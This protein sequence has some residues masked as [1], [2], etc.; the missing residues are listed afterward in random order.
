MPIKSIE[1][2][3]A[4]HEAGYGENKGGHYA[5][6]PTFLVLRQWPL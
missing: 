2:S 3:K 4:A 1:V 5:L 6:A